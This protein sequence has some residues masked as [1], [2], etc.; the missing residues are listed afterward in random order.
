MIKES[1]KF[2]TDGEAIIAWNRAIRK[3]VP[4]E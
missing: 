1:P 2:D 3:E 4:N